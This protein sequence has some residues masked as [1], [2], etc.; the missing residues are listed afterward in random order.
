MSGAG[1]IRLPFLVPEHDEWVSVRDGHPI[2]RPMMNRHY[3]ARRYRDGRQ[4]P[5]VIGPGEY[6]ALVSRDAMAIFCWRKALMMDGQTGVNCSVFRNEGRSQSSDLIRQ[7]MAR[8]WSRWPGERLFTYVNPKKIRSSNPGYCFICAGW[9]RCGGTKGGLVVL[10][11]IP[12]TGG[13]REQL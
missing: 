8:A 3:S 2:L 4:P 12:R 10:E 7:A 13:S 1:I 5:K 9:R 11:V 6:M